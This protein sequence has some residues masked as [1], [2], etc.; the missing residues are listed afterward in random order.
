MKLLIY[1]AIRLVLALFIF[2]LTSSHTVLAFPNAQVE[3]SP[4]FVK[5]K[6][7]GYLVVGVKYDSPP[8]GYVDNE[9]ELMGFEID[10]MREFAHRWLGDAKAVE[11]V[12][13]ISSNR[14]ERLLSGDIDLIAATMTYTQ[15][16]DKTIDFSQ[17]Y[18]LDGQ[19]ILIRKDSGLRR[20]N[21][22]E[23]I[24]A[25]NDNRI[26]AVRDST[27]IQQIVEFAETYGI[28]LTVAEF[29]QYDQVLKPLLEKQVDALTTDRGILVGL[30]QQHPELEILLDSNLSMEPYALG[31]PP[32]DFAF[33]ALVNQTLQEMKQDGTY[34]Q[35]YGKWFP[36]QTPYTLDTTVTPEAPQVTTMPVV[37]ET[38]T[39]T[40][41]ETASLTPTTTKVA[42]SR[43][44][45]T[46]MHVSSTVI[47]NAS[48][49]ATTVST[50]TLPT[51]T[52]TEHSSTDLNTAPTGFP[53]T[54][55]SMRSYQG[56]PLVV[57]FIVMLF[58]GSIYHKQTRD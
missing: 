28:K 41:T 32:G 45:S 11:F 38:A 37:T 13:V 23:S 16:R 50:A 36:D 46:T 5:I 8:F 55:M 15:E 43:V 57:L 3:N 35:I 56:I 9:G 24:Q 1:K 42:S 21:D 29:E 25:L 40:A 47:G 26:A 34:N 4:T 12:Q 53:P 58:I 27:S 31:L 6:E 54:G 51:A 17:T 22:S 33:A 7:R 19:N 20:N 30:Q 44:I 39:V 18:Y 49:T 2:Y 48:S 14:I 10:L 52:S